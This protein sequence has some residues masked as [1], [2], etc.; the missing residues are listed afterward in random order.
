MDRVDGNEAPV[1]VVGAG[2]VGIAGALYLQREGFRVLVLDPRSPGNATSFGNAGCL[3]GSSVVP[4]SMPGM[5]RDVPRWL[6]DP[7]G[8]LTIRLRYLPRLAPWLWRFLRAGT[9]ERVRDQA[10]ALRALVGPTVETY[11]DIAREAGALDLIRRQGHLVAY[12]SEESFAKDLDAMALRRANG[13]VVDDLG[14]DELRQLDPNLS[15]DYVRGRFIGE[16][17]HVTD[18]GGLVRRLAEAVRRNGGAILGEH[19]EGFATEHGRVTGVKTDRGLHPA[20]HVVIAAGAWSKPLAAELGDKVPLDTERGYHIVLKDPELRPRLPTLSAED[21]FIATPMDEGIRFAGTVEFAG[22]EAA[23]DWRRADVLLRQGLRMYPGLPRHIPEER[24]SRWMGFRPSLPDSLP[25]IG[26]A[27]R[28]GNVFYGFGHG[29]IGL[30]AG[31]PT[32]R[33]IAALVAGRSPGIDLAP[34]RVNRF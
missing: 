27:T 13:V 26:P 32:G 16:N 19:V 34:F 28:F 11:L 25:V 17:G 8:P 4:M 14:A 24:L 9:P 21:K 2:I 29:H 23:P 1:V 7:E 31:A 12:R 6:L 5:L 30:A 33:V 3:N 22:L 18:P 15:R 10:R 20:S